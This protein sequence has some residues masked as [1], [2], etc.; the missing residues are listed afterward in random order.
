MS[1]KQ[2][3]YKREKLPKVRETY[4]I[5]ADLALGMEELLVTDSMIGVTLLHRELHNSI[6]TPLVK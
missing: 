4:I 2:H 6:C 1:I 3:P 5:V